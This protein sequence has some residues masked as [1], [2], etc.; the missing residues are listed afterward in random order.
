MA[1]SSDYHRERLITTW[2]GGGL[3]FFQ[4]ISS[5]ELG[6]LDQV[7]CY[8]VTYTPYYLQVPGVNIQGKCL[9]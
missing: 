2:A 9:L 7:S 8:R 3:P 4:E 6:G 5:G 1:S